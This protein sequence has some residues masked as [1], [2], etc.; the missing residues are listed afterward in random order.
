MYI[1][2]IYYIYYIYIYTIHIYYSVVFRRVPSCSVVFRHVPVKNEQNRW[3][4]ANNRIVETGP[5]RGLIGS[6]KELFHLFR[7][8]RFWGILGPCARYGGFK[9]C[10][11]LV[12]AQLSFWGPGKQLLENSFFQSLYIILRVSKASKTFPRHPSRWTCFDYSVVY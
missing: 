1:H 10:A 7:F 12:H 6:N 8:G 4:S 11:I 9:G 5:P 3:T 2:Y